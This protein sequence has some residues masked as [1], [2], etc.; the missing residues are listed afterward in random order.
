MQGLL[1]SLTVILC[2]DRH[3][4]VA[5]DKGWDLV[6]ELSGLSITLPCVG[7]LLSETRCRVEAT[8]A[9]SKAEAKLMSPRK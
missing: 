3:V 1:S 9:D 2:L 6:K 4:V 7:N 5:R 8:Y